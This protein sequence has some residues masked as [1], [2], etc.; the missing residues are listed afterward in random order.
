MHDLRTSEADV[1][2]VPGWGSDDEQQR[3]GG[4]SGQN[5][6]DS[7]GHMRGQKEDQASEEDEEK[8]EKDDERREDRDESASPNAPPRPYPI[9][10]LCC[11]CGVLLVMGLEALAEAEHSH[12]PHTHT[13]THEHVLTHVHGDARTL[14][15]GEDGVS[16]HTPETVLT[17]RTSKSCLRHSGKASSHGI[18]REKV[19]DTE[20]L[21]LFSSEDE[22]E[23]EARESSE[24]EPSGQPKEVKSRAARKHLSG[25]LS[26]PTS[27]LHQA[28]TACG[29]LK[30][31]WQ[32]GEKDKKEGEGEGDDGGGVE[33]GD[34][35]DDRTC[36]NVRGK[37]ER[38]K[39]GGE[40]EKDDA[41]KKDETDEKQE[42]E[43]MTGSQEACNPSSKIIHSCGS[44]PSSKTASLSD[45][46]SHFSR[47]TASSCHTRFSSQAVASAKSLVGGGVSGAG[48]VTHGL[49]PHSHPHHLDL[50]SAQT[51]FKSLGSSYHTLPSPPFAEGRTQEKGGMSIFSRS[52]SSSS[53]S[54]GDESQGASRSYRKSHSSRS[55]YTAGC[56]LS[57]AAQLSCAPS[58]TAQCGM[59]LGAGKNACQCCLCTDHENPSQASYLTVLRWEGGG[60]RRHVGDPEEERT[61]QRG[62]RQGLSGSPLSACCGSHVG[63]A[64]FVATC[65]YR[66]LSEDEKAE[67]EVYAVVG[68][69]TGTKEVSHP[70]RKRGGAVTAN[71]ECGAHM[72]QHV[73]RVETKTATRRF[74]PA[75]GYSRSADQLGERVL[76]CES[77]KGGHETSD[78]D[79]NNHAMSTGIGMGSSPTGKENLGGEKNTKSSCVMTDPASL[80]YP[81]LA[82]AS[83]PCA[84]L[85]STPGQ[86]AHLLP[87]HEHE[88][89]IF[90]M[91][92]VHS[93]PLSEEEKSSG[94]GRP[95]R[96]AR[97]SE[98][99][100]IFSAAPGGGAGRR[101]IP[102]ASPGGAAATGC[103]YTVKNECRNLCS[104]Q[105]ATSCG[106][107]SSGHD[108][109]KLLPPYG[110]SSSSASIA[111][112]L[113]HERNRGSRPG[114]KAR[115]LL[116]S[117]A[118]MLALSFHSL[119]EGV[120]LGTTLNPQLVA[121]AVLVHKALE[122]FALGSSLL[123]AQTRV[124]TFIWQMTLFAGMTPAGVLLGIVATY[125]TQGNTSVA[126][127][128][129]ASS[130]T[131]SASS[132][133]PLIPG[134][135]TGVG[136]GTFLHVSLLECIAPQLMRC[137]S[138]GKASLLSVVAAVCVGAFVMILLA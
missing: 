78:G 136:S 103:M 52:M 67:S 7:A 31:G 77:Q 14:H 112:E 123:Q 70:C 25:G 40:V 91:P 13:H 90:F 54:S 17:V 9:A 134:L 119:M 130:A 36:K 34:S 96:D 128:V 120:T 64:E 42:E 72:A 124:R 71:F 79:I 46:S 109:T 68:K 125:L 16:V 101:F 18:Q 95:D 58:A 108:G 28:F 89:G 83:P 21:I 93:C 88:G 66:L 92:S 48:G 47:R 60:R 76:S 51:V 55:A 2:S 44:A 11:L 121:F 32:A 122:S 81:L 4:W 39:T 84:S 37:Q 35:S 133:L 111:D 24:S 63:G 12:A 29:S 135:L 53:S 75:M 49:P 20:T 129:A 27:A 73:E 118:L 97:S 110:S 87:G 30:R 102:T 43:G 6:D 85:C 104:N 41:N 3:K 106:R 8:A 38:E 65:P 138:E 115:D 100:A 86:G 105:L 23:V 69:D 132:L 1:L 98:R 80:A 5:E 99:L 56:A 22:L 57:A 33:S 126:R 62:K 116:V 114:G 113:E 131:A 61:H 45:V 10:S 117:S 137:R 74:F 50:P 19:S 127:S 59:R 26:S 107:C 94:E 15:L 82:F